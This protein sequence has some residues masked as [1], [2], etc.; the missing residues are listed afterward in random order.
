M[1]KRPAVTRCYLCG[2]LLGLETRP[3]SLDHIPPKQLFAKSLRSSKTRFYQ[4]RTHESCNNSFKLDEQYFTHALV[5]FGRG[6]VAGDAVR[7]KMLEEY[8]T[9]KQTRLVEK[10]LHSAKSEINGLLLPPGKI[11]LDYELDRVERVVGKI[12]KGLHLLDTGEIIRL[13]SDITMR[14][15]LP[16][17]EPPDDF[18][19]LMDNVPR[20]SLGEHQ[21]VFAYRSFVEDEL[22]YWALLI[23]DKI[24]I[25]ACFRTDFEKIDVVA[26][27]GDQA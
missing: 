14:I 3:E 26:A 2:E 7:H 1:M 6:S 18:V 21:G 15:T 12:I 10:I 5:P 24:I 19:R 27:G 17:E 20:P 22:H 16:G 23:W 25:T 9:G 4:V 11:W 13:P 8:H